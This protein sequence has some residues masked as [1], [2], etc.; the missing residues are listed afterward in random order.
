MRAGWRVAVS[1]G[2]AGECS[3]EASLDRGRG[4]ACSGSRAGGGATVR[5]R[6]VVKP[7]SARHRFAPDPSRILRPQTHGP[8]PADVAAGW[9]RARPVLLQACLSRAHP[10]SSSR[11]ASS[12][13]SL[14]VRVC[15]R[16]IR[17]GS[18]AKRR[19]ADPVLTTGRPRAV[20]PPPAREP[21]H[22]G[23]RRQARAA[24]GVPPAAPAHPDQ[25]PHHAHPQPAAPM[26]QDHR[27]RED[28][29]R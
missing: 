16:R 5:G 28:R 19:L 22:A 14:A 7:G 21:E 29:P 4:L 11:P 18:G 15:G 26:P 25:G 3:G 17:D 8:C 13:A 9:V 23:P 2:V 12:F 10:A 1:G 20:A 27:Q 6:P 24:P